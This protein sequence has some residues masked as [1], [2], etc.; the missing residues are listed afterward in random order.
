MTTL[1]IHN[2]QEHDSLNLAAEDYASP[3]V[4]K[5]L[6]RIEGT[7][8]PLSV[9]VPQDIGQALIDLCLV[10]HLTNDEQFKTEIK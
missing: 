3:S 2:R 1:H 8:Y 9:P 7:E 6:D 10:W 5:W 4:S